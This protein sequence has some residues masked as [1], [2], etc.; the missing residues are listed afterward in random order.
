MFSKK[1]FKD[2][3]RA[4]L[5]TLL[6]IAA[7]A[8][9]AE[10]TSLSYDYTQNWLFDSTS[11]LYWQALPVSTA[12]FVPDVGTI[13]TYEQLNDLLDH[14]GQNNSGP[15]WSSGP[16][17]L[18]VANLLSFFEFGTPAA[19]AP[20]AV[21]GQPYFLVSGIYDYG[22]V[23][24]SPTPNKFE[25]AFL[26]YGL[27]GT[28]TAWEFLYNSTIGSYGPN[29][30]CP[31]GVSGTCPATELGFIVS[32]VQPVPLPAALWLLISGLGGLGLLRR[33]QVA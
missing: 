33:R 3:R 2:T 9:H 6:T 8:S 26:T 19:A 15:Y 20:N 4:I 12:T 28:S 27:N 24:Q 29:N 25:Y 7:W 21:P 1:P 16:Y 5:G 14:V 23:Y 30:P 22:S 31:F 32:T 18:S 11:G 13:A 10:A 17:S